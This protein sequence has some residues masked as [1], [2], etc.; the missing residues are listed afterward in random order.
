[1]GQDGRARDGRDRAGRAF[2]LKQ[3][4]RWHWISSAMCLVGMLLFAA[5]GITLNHAARIEAK[6]R[7]EHREASLPAPL[8]RALAGED[9]RKGVALPA[10]VADWIRGSIDVDVAGRP[11]DW[12]ADE[13]Y[14]S[15][16]QIGR[17]HV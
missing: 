13:I 3:L 15:M 16:P 1:M 8:L 14:L 2:W 6:P 17:A 7:T 9:E 5:T 11:A 4:H 12:S 10:V